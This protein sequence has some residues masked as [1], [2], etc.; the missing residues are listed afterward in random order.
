MIIAIESAS[1]DASV[2]IAA[3]DGSPLAED[4]WSADRRQAGEL[5]PHLLALL[6][7][8]GRT[9]GEATVIA[10]GL[11][12]G[13]FTGLRVGLS[14]AKG[15]SLALRRPIV[16]V[17]SLAAWLAAEPQAEAALSRAGAREAFLLIRGAE[18][19]QI[20]EAASLPARATRHGPAGPDGQ[21]VVVAPAELAEAFGLAHALPPRRGASAVA[22]LAAER[23]RLE[24]AGDD[25]ARLEPTY[26]R[27]PR[28]IGPAA[29]G[30]VKWL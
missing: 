25:L 7:R 29:D 8:N 23:L 17:A 6:E 3:P 12:P 22:R 14:V 30:A 20:V 18:T 11:G 16:G 2:A 4:G 1:Q 26:F 28:G 10:V 27:G 5:F 24:P 13:S 9:L 21:G 15:L 19:P